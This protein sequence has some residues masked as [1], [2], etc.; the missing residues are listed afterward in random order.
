[1]SEMSRRWPRSLAAALAALPVLLGA[2]T[3]GA[4]ASGPDV[5]RSIAA[6]GDFVRVQGS[7]GVLCTEIV[8][9][10]DGG[11]VASLRPA[12][13]SGIPGGAYDASFQVPAEV[14]GVDH[15]VQV[16]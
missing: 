8:V 11:T 16:T 14:S 10:F 4:Q 2:P 7:F 13:G 3:A 15:V 1:M 12:G 9:R 5:D 6:P